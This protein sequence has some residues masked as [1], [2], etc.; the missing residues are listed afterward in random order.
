[1]DLIESREK[2]REIIEDHIKSQS[3]KGK[4][5]QILEAGCGRR[6]QLR[7]DGIDYVLTGVDLD[8]TALK[9]RKDDIGDLHEA[10]EG[11][12]RSVQLPEHQYDV[13]YSS[14]VLEHIK[15][16]EQVLNNFNRWVKPGGLVIIRI[17]DPHSV[18]GFITRM[19]PHWFH[20]LYYRI[21]LGFPN[22]GKP[23]YE[24]YPVDYDPVVSRRGIK[25]FCK[26]HGFTVMAEYGDG[27][28]R[29]GK[30]IARLLIHSVKVVGSILSLG[31]LSWRHS[32]LLYILRK[33]SAAQP[34]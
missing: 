33:Q 30:G 16:A 15:G 13:I 29:P 27:Y 19:T 28:M 11:D 31:A 17:P 34:V 23:G 20:V 9:M 1:M 12:L 14:Y 6:W 32:N 24:P 21:F 8:A 3:T 25:D 10:V 5:L 22:A 26:K 4:P 2:E 7:L 18:H